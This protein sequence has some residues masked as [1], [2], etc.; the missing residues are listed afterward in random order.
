MPALNVNGRRLSYVETGGGSPV[1]LCVHGAGGSAGTWTRQLE[2]LADAARVIAL[3]L[4][5]H[6]GSA[7]DGAHAVADYAAVVRAFITALG[8]GPVVLAGH[9]MGGAV[10]QTLALEAPALLRGLV[11]VGTGGRLRVAPRLLELIEQDYPAG[12]D[13]VT[14]HAWSPASA[15]ALKDGGR[16]ATLETRA[17]VTLGDYRACDAFDVM[18]RLGEIRLPTLVL[19]GADDE[20]TP[21][22]Y[23]EFLAGSIPGARLAGIPRAGH[24]PMLEQPD[25]V[26]H[27]IRQFLSVAII[28]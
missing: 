2:G 14:A 24:Y 19:V 1:L 28:F 6:G 11:L 12:V 20:M 26:N 22:K 10:A 3:D 9:S 13:W 17:A 5:G 21:P 15:P 4:P 8:G 23:A 16:R 27:A 7:G 25:E 18:A